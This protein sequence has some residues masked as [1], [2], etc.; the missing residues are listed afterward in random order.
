MIDAD[1]RYAE[2]GC[3]TLPGDD[4]VMYLK[5]RFLPAASDVD[6]PQTLDA[7]AVPR[8]RLDLVAAHA[9]GDAFAFWRICD[10]NE[11]MNPAT[12]LDDTGNR[13]RIPSG[14]SQ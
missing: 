7:A 14:L 5:R 8:H 10:A 13:L 3:D 6:A 2:V 12:L 4:E 1:S 9:L 11:A